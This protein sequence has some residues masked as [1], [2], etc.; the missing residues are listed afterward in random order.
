[1]T[2]TVVFRA[3]AP[4][5]SWG[6]VGNASDI[7]P[8]STH[9]LPSTITGLICSAMNIDRSDTDGI[10]RIARASMVFRLDQQGNIRNEFQTISNTLSADLKPR[11]TIMSQRGELQDACIT[12]FCTWPDD[13]GTDVRDA[14]RHPARPLHLGRTCHLI[15]CF[16][17]ATVINDTINDD[18]LGSWAAC[19]VHRPRNNAEWTIVESSNL[20]INTPGISLSGAKAR[21]FATRDHTLMAMH[22]RSIPRTQQDAKPVAETPQLFFDGYTVVTEHE[23]NRP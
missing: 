6:A 19:N 18:L 1:M 23:R 12:I 4:T 9:P 22:T 2:T 10:A 13:T 14:L 3:C 15:G 20:P 5:Q 21:N 8:T 11:G 16:P 17:E 7:R